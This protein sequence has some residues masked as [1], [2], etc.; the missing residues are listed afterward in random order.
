MIV[1][2]AVGVD[3]QV[4]DVQDV[5]MIETQSNYYYYLAAALWADWPSF[6]ISATIQNVVNMWF[7]WCQ[8]DKGTSKSPIY[9]PLLNFTVKCTKGVQT[10]QK[11]SG[12]RSTLLR[13]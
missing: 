1:C 3:E 7:W 4:S 10:S 9:H 8:I 5:G 11:P 12:T 2:L 6:E 13:R